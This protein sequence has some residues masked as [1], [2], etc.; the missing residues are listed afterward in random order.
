MAT[1]AA[2][3]FLIA[4]VERVTEHAFSV[5]LPDGRPGVVAVSDIA[6]AELGDRLTPRLVSMQLN[7]HARLF[8]SDATITALSRQQ[9]VELAPDG[10]LDDG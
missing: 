5:R 6:I 7:E 1:L 8:G 4:D 10:T 3:H 2:H 9:G